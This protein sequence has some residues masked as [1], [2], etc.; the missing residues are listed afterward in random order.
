MPRFRGGETRN[1]GHMELNLHPRF[2]DAAQYVVSS[3]SAS[4]SVLQRKFNLG[5]NSACSLMDQLE[6][7]GIVSS[8]N[9]GMPGM[10]RVLVKDLSSISE[11][12]RSLET[13]AMVRK[14]E[15]I[16]RKYRQM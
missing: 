12:V 4:V 10:R 15:E 11:I 3:Q 14:I 7:S 1:L 6:A 16:T 13:E 8:A 9:A 2:L 5:Y